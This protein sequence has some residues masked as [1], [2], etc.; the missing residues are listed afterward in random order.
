M[1]EKSLQSPTRKEHGARSKETAEQAQIRLESAK[2]GR[3]VAFE[4]H[5]ADNS[6]IRRS[7]VTP[8]NT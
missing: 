6:K 8:V 1:S 7:R 2:F 4:G 5:P 3:I